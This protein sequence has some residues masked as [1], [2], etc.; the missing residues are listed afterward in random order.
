M[1]EALTRARRP[2]AARLVEELWRFVVNGV[3]FTDAA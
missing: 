3:R 1:G 2:D